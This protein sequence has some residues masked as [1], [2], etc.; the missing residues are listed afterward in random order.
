MLSEDSKNNKI[1]SY[2]CA[3]FQVK[4][5][6]NFK[7]SILG[8]FIFWLFL[9]TIEVPKEYDIPTI[10]EV[11]SVSDTDGCFRQH[12]KNRRD[13]NDLLYCTFFSLCDDISI[14]SLHIP[15]IKSFIRFTQIYKDVCSEKCNKQK[16]TIPFNSPLLFFSTTDYLFSLRKIII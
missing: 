7:Y 2:L 14:N 11:V 5:G 3:V 9:G 10:S 12:E 13:I 1:K 6:I 4:M 16:Y 15:V 8:I